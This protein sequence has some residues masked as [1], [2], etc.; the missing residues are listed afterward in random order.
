MD[1]QYL[2]TPSWVTPRFF[3]V[4]TPLCPNKN[5]DGFS[6]GSIMLMHMVSVRHK[7]AFL[8]REISELCTLIDKGDSFASLQLWRL[9][10]G[11]YYSGGLKPEFLLFL[12]KNLSILSP[13]WC[14]L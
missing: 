8:V 4:Y 1:A 7:D 2:E 11:L 6:L 13:Y 3:I 14:N 9:A 10:Q 5:I 12:K